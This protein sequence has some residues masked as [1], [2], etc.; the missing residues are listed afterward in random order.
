M[1][2]IPVMA[3]APGYCWRRCRRFPWTTRWCRRV[4]GAHLVGVAAAVARRV[5]VRARHACDV[6]AES[7]YRSYPVA[8]D[9]APQA[10]LTLK[11]RTR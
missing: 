8:P 10:M 6:M 2:A 5:E 9:R 11:G 1:S 7:T 4:F 3:G